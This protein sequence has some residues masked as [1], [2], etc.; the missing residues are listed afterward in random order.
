M[1]RIKPSS[2]R[3]AGEEESGFCPLLISAETF[4]LFIAILFQGGQRPESEQPCS[5]SLVNVLLKGTSAGWKSAEL[6]PESFI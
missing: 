5:W 1:L 3:Q 6:E 4:F 2:D